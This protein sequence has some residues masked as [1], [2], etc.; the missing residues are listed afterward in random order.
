MTDRTGLASLVPVTPMANVPFW[1]QTIL[2][3]G[4]PKIGK[5]TF[6]SKFPNAIFFDAEQGTVGI[7][8]PTF[9]NLLPG[10]DRI[11]SPIST[12]DDVLAATTVLEGTK[13]RNIDGVVVIDTG[14]A[15]WEMCREYVKQRMAGT[16]D[17][18][19]YEGDL[20]H[21]KAWN[22][23]AAEFKSWVA[24][25]KGL[26]FGIVFISHTDSKEFKDATRKYEKKV[27]R[28][29][30]GPRKIIEPFVNVIL[31]AET[32]LK[33]G[34]ECRIVHTK[35]TMHVSAGE[36]GENPRLQ[37]MLPFDYDAISRNWEGEVIDLNVWFGFAPAQTQVA[38]I[39]APPPTPPVNNPDPGV[40]AVAREFDATLT[41]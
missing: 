12:W 32:I 27:A 23:V 17:A 14:P 36:R 22:M 7:D 37:A 4:D 33:A 3:H 41:N 26:G 5:T 2:L 19:D 34:Q 20:A 8:V 10:R 1:R 18:W 39:T 16:R 38:G 29:G 13:G 24:R 11:N 40:A 9:E 15:A 35:P 31:Y 28:M 6:A 25:I 30:S 21:G